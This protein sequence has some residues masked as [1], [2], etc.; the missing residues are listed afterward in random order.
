MI[1]D[2]FKPD[3]FTTTALTASINNVAYQPTLLRDLGIFSVD[4]VPTT[5][6]VVEREGD[7][8]ALV[9]TSERGAPGATQVEVKRD[10]VSL[11]IP[12]LQKNDT[13]KAESILGVRQ[14]GSEDQQITVEQARDKKLNRMARDLDFTLEYHRLGAI[15]GRVLD[16]DGVSVLVNLFTVFGIAEPTEIDFDLDNNTPAVGVVARKCN[17]VVYGMEAALGGV[18]YTGI[19]ALCDN[20]FWD[21]LTTHAEVRETFMFQQ[22]A[23]RLRE[24][25]VNDV[26]HF[27]GID[28]QRYRGS[29]AVAVGAGKARFFPKGVPDL[30]QT[31]FA[32]A[33]YWD[34]V[35][36]PG[37]PRYAS[38]HMLPHNKGVDLE[39][40][41]NPLN[42]CTRPGVLLRARNT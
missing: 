25:W 1:P 9:P 14:F 3:F 28:W 19:H 22:Q 10:A 40:Q 42:I 13:L 37:L 29:G 32:P 7:L 16:S 24:S 27:G 39:A 38:A 34:A 21:Q 4:G 30:F 6:I 15:Q 26:F 8:L 23:A 5:S 18:P 36:T 2:P 20:T 12:H 41:S 35:N 33:D 17:E 11:L 31:V